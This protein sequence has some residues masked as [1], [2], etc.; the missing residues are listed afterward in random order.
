MNPLASNFFCYSKGKLVK[1][2]HVYISTHIQKEEGL[3]KNSY[4]P[5]LSMY[6]WLMYNVM[7]FKHISLTSKSVFSNFYVKNEGFDCLVLRGDIFIR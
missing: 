3:K 7:S 5:L 4:V 1:N 2:I 6:K